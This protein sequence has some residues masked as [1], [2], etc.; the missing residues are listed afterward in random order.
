MV[1]RK[2][3]PAGIAVA[4]TN[5][6]IYSRGFGYS[7][8]QSG[9][10]ATPDTLYCAGSVSKLFTATAVMQLAEKGLLDIDKPVQNYIREFRVK[11]NFSNSCPITIR[12]IL[13]HR[14]GLP[15][16][17]QFNMY[18]NDFFSFRDS[19]PYIGY[20]YL[21]NPPGL[22]FSYCNLGYAVL[23]VLIE[24][25]SG[26][27]FYSYMEKN[28]LD[29]LDMT[30]SSFIMS[31]RNNPLC[32]KSYYNPGNDINEPPFWAAPAAG[33][34]T[35]PR[36]MGNFIGMVLNG[37]EFHG[38]RIL[39]SD[40]LKE[41]FRDDNPG[42]NLDF[43]YRQGLGW[44]IDFHAFP[45][46]G[47]LVWHGGNT[48][49]FFSMLKILPESGVGV[50]YEA[51][52][53]GGYSSSAANLALNEAFRLMEI[54]KLPKLEKPPEVIYNWEANLETNFEKITGDYSTTS[55]I[56]KISS[57]NTGLRAGL[58]SDK[59]IN[60]GL[61]PETNGWFSGYSNFKIAFTRI[62]G[63]IYLIRKS[64][65]NIKPFGRETFSTGASIDWKALAGNYH[66]YNEDW[67]EAITRKYGSPLILSLRDLGNLA[68]FYISSPGESY[69][70]EAV[71]G[72]EAVIMGFGN[73]FN[74]ATVTV[75]NVNNKN[76]LELNGYLF[77][78]N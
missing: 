67:H 72:N 65:N 4:G 61:K 39:K 17:R 52:G 70:L 54:P 64:K 15:S 43:G 24:R 40:T 2:F 47:E 7:D 13:T 29:P 23:G 59:K 55:G 8:L 76:M 33:L 53:K 57:D 48:F 75:T 66:I 16:D 19:I 69:K 26:I 46:R 73:R 30:N 25:V 32:A 74:G 41:M 1:N 31:N 71:N 35:S 5:G 22:I 21:Q 44:N 51:A 45:S 20:H 9:I 77:E 6:I 14:S 28:I 62:N 56:F 49:C 18:T 11:S 58:I 68:W 38:R 78:R 42:P 12:M 3:G 37:G 50:I 10:L 36:E 34:W 27:D 63:T 60:Y